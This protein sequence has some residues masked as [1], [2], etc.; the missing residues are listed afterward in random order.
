MNYSLLIHCLSR[1]STSKKRAVMVRVK[2]LRCCGVLGGKREGRAELG[3][4]A[5]TV[6]RSSRG[7]LIEWSWQAGGASLGLLS[8]ASAHRPITDT[9]EL[10]KCHF[11]S[12]GRPSLLPLYHA[13][14]PPWGKIYIFK[15]T[16]LPQGDGITTTPRVHVT[17]HDLQVSALH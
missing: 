11:P 7:S 12:R 14:C 15:T 6:K 1:T 3:L 10:Q 13:A 5:C 2:M 16:P 9:T 4:G 17:E 8:A